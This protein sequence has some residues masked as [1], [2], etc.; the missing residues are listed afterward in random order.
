MLTYILI[1]AHIFYEN[2]FNVFYKY[3]IFQ[4]RNTLT[5][6]NICQIYCNM[7]TVMYCKLFMNYMEDQFL[8]MYSIYALTQPQSCQSAQVSP[9]Q[10]GQWAP[11]LYLSEVKDEGYAGDEDEVKEADSGKKMSH[12]SKVCAS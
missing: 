9:G 11:V 6:E 10:W 12:F 3:S 4:M 2:S 7:K 1:L 8:V 5:K